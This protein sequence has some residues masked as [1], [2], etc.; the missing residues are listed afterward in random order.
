MRLPCTGQDRILQG[1]IRPPSGNDKS[2]RAPAPEPL[3]QSTRAC[4]VPKAFR[5]FSIGKLI[6]QPLEERFIYPRQYFAASNE[7]FFLTLVLTWAL[8]LAFHPEQIF[9]HPARRFIGSLNPWCGCRLNSGPHLLPARLANSSRSMAVM[10]HPR[11]LHDLLIPPVR[12]LSHSMA[13]DYPPASYIAIVM[14]SANVYFCWRYAFLEHMRT[15]L[16][17]PGALSAVEKFASASAALLAC[18]SNFWLLLWV[19]VIM[20][21]PSNLTPADPPAERLNSVLAVCSARGLVMATGSCTPASSSF[22]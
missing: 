6:S 16:L 22:T 21:S 10:T 3:S 20:P 7:T 8:T 11:P 12:F 15:R 4:N 9:E 2:S 1:K 18:A 13:W 5:W 17:N 19:I 14:C